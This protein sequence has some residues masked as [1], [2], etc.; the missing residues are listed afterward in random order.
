MYL[1]QLSVINFKNYAEKELDFCTKINCFV[2]NNGVGKTNLL[3]AIYYLSFCKSYFNSID[4][5]NISHG[6]D[7]FVIQGV[8][9]SSNDEEK[10]DE[11][12]CAQKRN[13]RKVF[14]INKKEYERLADHI[15]L[16]PLVMISPADSDL[17]YDGSEHRR[18]FL[19]S[20]ISQFDKAYLDN[21]INY[22]KVVSQRNALLK[23]FYEL[24]SFD[25][26]SLEIWDEQMI[27]YG[28]RIYDKRVHFLT[29][30]LPLFR[31]YYKL[32]SNSRENVDIIYDSQ[33]NENPFETV[34]NKAIDK[35]RI[36]QYST[37]GPHKDDLSFKIDD[38]PAKKFGSQGQQKS[39]IIALKL[40]QFDY[41]K[42]LKG[43]KPILLFDDIFDKLDNLRVEQLMKLVSDN[44][45]GQVFITDTQEERIKH[46]FDKIDTDCKIFY[47]EQN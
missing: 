37:A 2:G 29:E 3:D 26:A 38:F 15:G 17:I 42:S 25:K 45:Y 18:K 4:S 24:K 28:Q 35:D 31:N 33:L 7:F 23:K 46:V 41:I 40:A 14:K 30:F 8:Y 13:H 34:L 12:Y 44:N 39:F 32:I 10:T 5:Q 11:I 47:L 43:Y 16:F 6:E 9:T 36:L 21:L 27:K 20:A 22:N 19:D 1:R